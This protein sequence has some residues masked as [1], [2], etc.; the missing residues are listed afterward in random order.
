[1]NDT[2]APLTQAAKHLGISRQRAHQLVR[3]GILRAEQ[4][5]GRWL[6]PQEELVRLAAIVRLPGRP[7]SA[8]RPPAGSLK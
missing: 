2:H 4:I 5:A 3:R 8:A 1:M 6:V 7:R